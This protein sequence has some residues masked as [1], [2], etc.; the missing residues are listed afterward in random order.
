MPTIHTEKGLRK[1]SEMEATSNTGNA[2]PAEGA[3]VVSGT[4]AAAQGSPNAPP[5]WSID[6]IKLPDTYK[7]HD[8]RMGRFM[9]FAKSKS[10]TSA[11]AQGLVDLFVESGADMQQAVER[12]LLEQHESQMAEWEKQAR[13]DKDIGGAGFDA[14]LAVAQSAIARFGSPEA[15]AVIDAYGLGNHPAILKMFVAIGKAI[16]EGSHVSSTPGLPA[17]QSPEASIYNHPSSRATM[18]YDGR[19]A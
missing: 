3:A 1:M 10:L 16:S 12:A 8:E 7:I 2:A 13:A 19:A 5:E 6:P 18:K 15:K 17:R 11:E 14:N 4:S 9:D